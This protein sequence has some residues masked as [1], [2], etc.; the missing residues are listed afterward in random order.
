MAKRELAPRKKKRAFKRSPSKGSKREEEEA[1]RVGEKGAARSR[2]AANEKEI[3]QGR[4]KTMGGGKT[5]GKS[6]L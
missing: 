5:T 1:K 2:Y 6:R 4:R 3:R